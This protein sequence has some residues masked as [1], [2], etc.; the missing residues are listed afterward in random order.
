MA[1][2]VCACEGYATLKLNVLI[3]SVTVLILGVTNV[4]RALREE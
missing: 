1:E 3:L 4:I 2:A